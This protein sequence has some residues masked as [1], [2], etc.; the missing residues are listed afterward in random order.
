[1]NDR[2]TTGARPGA[3]PALSRLLLR[4][5]GCAAALGVALAAP[6]ALPL[7]AA[8]PAGAAQEAAWQQ[9]RERFV[10][11]DGRVVDTGNGGVSHSEGQGW[12]ML[13]AQ[14][15]DDRATFRQLHQWTRS[16]LR[17]RDDALHAWRFRPGTA[18]PVD[19][20]NNATDGD[21]YIAWALA[22]AGEAWADP[23][24]TA[25]AAAIGRDILRLL[26]RSVQGQL[27]LL[28]GLVGFEDG[29]RLVLNPSYLVF[30]AFAALERVLPDPR[31]RQLRSDGLALLRQA[32][33]GRWGLPPDWLAIAQPESRLA[34]AEGWPPRFS[35]DAVRVPLLLAWAGQARE[36][37]VLAALQF[38]TDPAHPAPPA[39]TDLTT[40][41]LADYPASGGVRAIAAFVADAAAGRQ[42]PAQVRI[43]T[44]DDYYSAAL[45][46][47]VSVAA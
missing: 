24:L 41:A 23:A 35:F 47:L 19:D 37:A 2:Q 45:K 14:A 12:G 9:F 27:W 21:L 16:T 5:R 3:L 10:T 39:W 11:A 32:R 1:M 28:P 29:R 43:E 30:P 20:P 40:N 44:A 42:R 31:W 6:L 22:R 36:P 33:F 13:L 34:P 18:T 4:R 38:W 46:M 8:R 15:Y 26:T 7:A 17:R 25:A